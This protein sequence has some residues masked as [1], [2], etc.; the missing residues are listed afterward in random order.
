MKTYTASQKIDALFAAG[1]MDKHTRE[2]IMQS[3]IRHVSL[4]L[5]SDIGQNGRS[6][7]DFVVSVYDNPAPPFEITIRAD[8]YVEPFMDYLEK[9]AKEYADEATDPT[10]HGLMEYIRERDRIWNKSREVIQQ[11]SLWKEDD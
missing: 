3:L 6:I 8:A 5:I 7:V 2:Y 1:P 10:P 11:S 4:E 9:L